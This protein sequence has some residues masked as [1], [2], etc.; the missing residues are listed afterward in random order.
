MASS[1]SHTGSLGLEA[2]PSAACGSSARARACACACAALA[3]APALAML[4][5]P[6]A[7][8]ERPTPLRWRTRRS[9]A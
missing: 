1:M 3:L 6:Q 2:E 9:R 7:P 4:G 8:E 5:R